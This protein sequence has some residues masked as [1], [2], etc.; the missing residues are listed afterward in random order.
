MTGSLSPDSY[1][2][3]AR[4]IIEKEGGYIKLQSKPGEGSCFSVFLPKTAC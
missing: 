1:T 3:L 4:E 2:Y